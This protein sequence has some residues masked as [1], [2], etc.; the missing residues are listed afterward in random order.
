MNS[1][2]VVLITGATKGIGRAIV[3]RFA[4]TASELHVVARNQ[5]DLNAM[6]TALERPGL[7]VA[8][9]CADLSKPE[10]VGALV[11]ELQNRLPRL[12]VLVNNAGVYLPGSLLEEKSDNLRYMMQLNVLSH[13]EI[14]R[15]LSS[16]MSSGSHII[17][18]ASVASRKLFLG[19]P[20]YSISKHAQ[21]TMVE[22][23]RHEF[24]PRGIRVT[25]IMP[26]PTWSASWEGVSFPKSRLLN[27][28]HIAEAVWSA[29]SLPPEAVIEEIVIRPFDGDIE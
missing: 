7:S 17:N 24:R 16:V 12:D 3:E 15:G 18:M 22:A 13:Y 27:A 23:F 2:P 11:V 29:W 25:S 21:A 5:D 28:D 6:K 8:V 19:K 26:G 14:T 4:A 1:N 20:S 10:E 9:Y